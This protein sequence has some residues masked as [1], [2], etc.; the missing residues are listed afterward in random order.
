M[1]EQRAIERGQKAMQKQT[2]LR[3][4]DQFEKEMKQAQITENLTKIQHDLETG[5]AKCYFG[6]T[7]VAEQ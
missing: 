2:A 5:A 1:L 3:E 7:V 4:K 6:K